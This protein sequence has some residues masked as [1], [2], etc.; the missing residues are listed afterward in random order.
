MHDEQT[1]PITDREILESD[2]AVEA[3]GR[4]A[5]PTMCIGD[6]GRSILLLQCDLDSGIIRLRMLDD[7]VP[8]DR[9]RCQEIWGEEEWEQRGEGWIG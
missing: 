1:E 7:A 2:G 5:F 8:R 9:E 3:L 6:D 4:D